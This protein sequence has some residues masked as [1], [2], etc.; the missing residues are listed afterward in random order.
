M[1]EMSLTEKALLEAISYTPPSST[2]APGPGTNP[3]DAK[4]AIRRCSAT[5]QRAFKAYMD[6]SDGGGMEDVWAA[7]EGN[8]AYCNAMPLLVGQDGIRDFIAC[9]AYGILIG[10]IPQDRC[11]QLL[12]AA[13]VALSLL[14]HQTKQ[15]SPRLV[16]PSRPAACEL[17]P[18]PSPENCPEPSA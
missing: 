11:S 13:Q 2:L 10:A 5:W 7:K 16:P 18:P 15:P 17:P 12:Y 14:Q 1:P 3:T 6:E 8:K 4:A 9:T